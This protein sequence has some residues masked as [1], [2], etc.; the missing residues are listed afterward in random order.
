MTNTG[1]SLRLGSVEGGIQTSI[2]KTAVPLKP[3]MRRNCV[4]ITGG[5]PDQRRT[6]CAALCRCDRT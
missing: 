5:A 1:Q 3:N 4:R 6:D 2:K